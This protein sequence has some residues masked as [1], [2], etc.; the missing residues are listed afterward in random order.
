MSI[1]LIEICNKLLSAVVLLYRNFNDIVTY[2][3]FSIFKC[4]ESVALHIIL[5]E[6]ACKLSRFCKMAH[7]AE[8]VGPC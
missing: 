5:L 1:L 3:L 4:C 8:V 6:V 2:L 7:R